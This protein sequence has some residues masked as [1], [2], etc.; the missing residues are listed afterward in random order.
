MIQGFDHAPLRVTPKVDLTLLRPVAQRKTRKRKHDAISLP[1]DSELDKLRIETLEAGRDNSRKDLALFGP[2][3]FS[4]NPVTVT[5]CGAC[6]NSG[7]H[8]NSAGAAAFFGQNSSLNCSI[9]V[10][11]AQSNARADLISLLL[12][13]QSAPK[14]KSLIVSTRSQY[15]TRAIK[16]Y[17]CVQKRRLWLVL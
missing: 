15:A 14:A 5:I 8:P 13:V 7:K 11:G 10:W 1:E 4:T 9:R 16:Y 3:L 12:A 17:L 6:K 2:V